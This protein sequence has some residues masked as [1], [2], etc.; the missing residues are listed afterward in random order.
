VYCVAG[1][2]RR[3]AR[4]GTAVIGVDEPAHDTRR[5]PRLQLSPGDDVLRVLA[6]P[7]FVTLHE[8]MLS[9]RLRVV[10][11]REVRRQ[12]VNALCEPGDLCS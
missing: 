2:S 6:Q 11:W 1:A 7:G 8:P 5:W 10:R 9:R 4:S 3:A 12:G